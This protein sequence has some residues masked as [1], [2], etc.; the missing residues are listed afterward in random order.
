MY[1]YKLALSASI[2]IVA[3][4]RHVL[5]PMYIFRTVSLHAYFKGAEFSSFQRKSQQRNNIDK[6]AGN[7]EKFPKRKNQR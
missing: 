2:L 3:T 7:I 4:G 1:S 6:L 5:Q